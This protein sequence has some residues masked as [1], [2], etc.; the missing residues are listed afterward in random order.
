MK[1]QVAVEYMIIVG[2]GLIM[3]FL[4]VNYL[5]GLFQSYSDENK[6]SLA[7]NSVYKIGENADLVFSQGPPAKVRVEIYIPESVQEIS[8]SNKTVLF[9]VK[10]SSG[11][12]DIF[13]NSIPQIIGILPIKSG[14]YYISLTS[15]QNYVNISVV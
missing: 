4:S 9:K 3:I 10:T 8:F 14:Q 1:A 2:V 7:K 6:I 5:L 13:Y 11:V 15:D 12:N